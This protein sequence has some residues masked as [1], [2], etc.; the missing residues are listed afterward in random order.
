MTGSTVA[1]QN[2][3]SR[4]DVFTSTDRITAVRARAK[5]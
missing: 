4:F 5:K 1:R 2:H 3:G